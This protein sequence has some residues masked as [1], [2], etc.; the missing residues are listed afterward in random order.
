LQRS[1]SKV[2]RNLLY[3][4]SIHSKY[5][6]SRAIYKISLEICQCHHHVDFISSNTSDHRLTE[7]RSKK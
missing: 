3:L 2:L 4:G 1:S 7:N 5:S 6:Q